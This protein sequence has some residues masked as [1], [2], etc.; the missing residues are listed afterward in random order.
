MCEPT[1]SV[2]ASKIGPQL[3]SPKSAHCD[4]AMQCYGAP[5]ND[6]EGQAR[7]AAFRQ[8]LRDLKWPQG[9]NIRVDI[10]W[11]AGDAYPL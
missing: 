3:L 10:R 9:S 8:G 11:G 7:I 1:S 4:A 2:W 5:Q 6:R